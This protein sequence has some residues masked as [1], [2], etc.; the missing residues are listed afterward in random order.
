MGGFTLA[1]LG[2]VEGL[3]RDL[4]VPRSPPREPPAGPCRGGGLAGPGQRQRGR[5]GPTP[6]RALRGA[7]ELPLKGFV[8]PVRLLEPCRA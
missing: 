5:V 6:E 3:R 8:R 1:W 2:F 4:T 7:G